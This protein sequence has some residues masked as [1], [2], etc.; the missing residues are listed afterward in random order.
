MA[1]EISRAPQQVEAKVQKCITAAWDCQSHSFM[2]S[3]ETVEAN[4]VALPDDLVQRRVYMLMIQGDD[5][6]EAR[7]FER[8]SLEDTDGTVSTWEQGDLGELVT[9]ITDVLV[10]NRGVHC[11]GEQVKA[12]IT[13][14]RDFIVEGPSAAPKT[15]AEAFSGPLA[16]FKNDKF[17]QAT[18]MMLC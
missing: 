17:V 2:G 12:T 10:R 8:F 3:P 13:E 18:V 14:E 5:R 4:L 15:A 1:V 6:A 7:V 16:A 11:P 9:Q